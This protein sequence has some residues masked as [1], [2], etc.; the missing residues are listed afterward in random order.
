[1]LPTQKMLKIAEVKNDFAVRFPTVEEYVEFMQGTYP[2]T[3]LK[4]M[5]GKFGA[6][7]CV[8][9]LEEKDVPLSRMNNTAA[10]CEALGLEIR[11]PAWLYTYNNDAL[12]KYSRGD[13][14]LVGM[15]KELCIVV[16]F[17]AE[18]YNASWKYEISRVGAKEV[19]S[20][21]EPFMELDKTHPANRPESEFINP[22]KGRLREPAGQK[23]PV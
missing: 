12:S 17:K 5:Y 11:D 20:S 10:A 13:R 21:L 7:T 8:F 15:G 23:K 1:M 18:A 14:V 2:L 16:G 22:D 3:V 19:L 9:V 4:T 6:Q